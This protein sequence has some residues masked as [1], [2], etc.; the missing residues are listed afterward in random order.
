[1]K[2]VWEIKES[3]LI[4]CISGH[5]T[6]RECHDHPEPTKQAGC[7]T[8]PIVGTPGPRSFGRTLIT[9]RSGT[10]GVTMASV[11]ERGT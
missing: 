9:R 1:M 11:A 6:L 2:R 8:R 4:D 3:G 7:I 10:L 5:G